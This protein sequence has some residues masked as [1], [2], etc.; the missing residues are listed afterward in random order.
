MRKKCLFLLTTAAVFTLTASAGDMLNAKKR[1]EINHAE[2]AELWEKY[3]DFCSIADWHPAVSMCELT[4]E[5][6][7][8]YRTLTL[9]EGGVI[10]E[11]Y[12][13]EGNVPTS[14]NYE[15]VESPLP[16][17]KYTAVFEVKADDDGGS[18][19]KWSADF[20]AAGV[21]DKEAEDIVE[22]IFKAGLDAIDD[23]Y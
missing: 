6:G 15:I 9:A 12:L 22:G 1:I 21:P 23:S 5:E 7:A 13:G 18:G 10:K 3:G 17:E 14:Y 11:K 20:L 2:P 8:T 16:V 19:I 4:E